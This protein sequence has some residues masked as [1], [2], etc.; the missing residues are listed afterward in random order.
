MLKDQIGMYYTLLGL[1]MLPLALLVIFMLIDIERIEAVR[2]QDVSLAD[3]AALAAASTATPV[4]DYMYTYIYDVGGNI[5]GVQGNVGTVKV[6]IDDP[7]LAEGEARRAALKNMG[8]LSNQA[9]AGMIEVSINQAPGMADDI[10]GQKVLDDTYVVKV[11][12]SLHTFSASALS[13][14][15]GLQGVSKDMGATA[16]GQAVIRP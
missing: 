13:T 8:A 16:Y 14:L 6:V 5:A 1:I 9:N 11:N 3:S 4:I 12:S 15:Y 7:V 10:H 2:G